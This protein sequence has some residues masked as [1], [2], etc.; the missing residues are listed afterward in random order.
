MLSNKKEN[1]VLLEFICQLHSI[2]LIC[3]KGDITV[4]KTPVINVVSALRLCNPPAFKLYYRA[5]MWPAI[6]KRSFLCFHNNLMSIP[7]ESKH[8][9]EYVSLFLL[10]IYNFTI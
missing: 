7:I 8:P 10:Q 6:S 1:Q 2:P 5:I 9:P 4:M 3:K